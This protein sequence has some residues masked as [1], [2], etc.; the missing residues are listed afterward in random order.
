MDEGFDEPTAAPYTVYQ[1]TDCY[2]LL[3]INSFSHN[4]HNSL[5]FDEGLDKTL[6]LRVFATFFFFWK[7]GITLISVGYSSL[8]SLWLNLAI[9]LISILLAKQNVPTYSVWLFPQCCRRYSTAIS[10]IHSPNFWAAPAKKF[11][12]SSHP[13]SMVVGWMVK[14]SKLFF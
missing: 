5:N 1:C 11:S 8:C 9:K 12:T 4:C 3:P 14:I 13:S 10:I 2:I 7:I 6:Q